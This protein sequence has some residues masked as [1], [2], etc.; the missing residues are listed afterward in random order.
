MVSITVCIHVHG[1]WYTLGNCICFS[2]DYK[3]IREMSY[4]FVMKIIMTL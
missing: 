3:L 1:L 4:L 2:M